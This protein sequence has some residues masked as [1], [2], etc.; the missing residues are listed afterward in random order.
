MHLQKVWERCLKTIFE[1]TNCF[2]NYFNLH[3]QNKNIS[4]VFFFVDDTF[5]MALEQK[6]TIF[7]IRLSYGGIISY[8]ALDIISIFLI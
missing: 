4:R 5:I 8:I 2:P 1:R 7:K 3:I 6:S